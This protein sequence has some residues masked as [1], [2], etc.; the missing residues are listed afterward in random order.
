MFINEDE[1]GIPCRICKGND[2]FSS[3]IYIDI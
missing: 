3:P 1:C 2:L